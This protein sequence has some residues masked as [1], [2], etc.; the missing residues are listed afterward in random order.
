MAAFLAPSFVISGEE[1][2]VFGRKTIATWAATATL[3][4]CIA[5]ADPCF[6]N[7]RNEQSHQAVPRPPQAT[8]G[9]AQVRQPPLQGHHA[10][11]WLRQ[12][13]DVPLDQQRR[14][15]QNDPQFRRLP[16]QQ[17]QRY[18]QRLQDFSRRSP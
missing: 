14:A 6:A 9:R 4:F 13:K 7:D 18:I 16:P 12:Y 5:G 17:Q 11:Q 2:E 10:G 3:V 15:L 1:T 8:Q